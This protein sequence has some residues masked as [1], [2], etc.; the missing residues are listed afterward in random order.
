[1]AGTFD[2]NAALSNNART[3]ANVRRRPPRAAVFGRAIYRGP[4]WPPVPGVFAG[5]PMSPGASRKN[6][7]YTFELVAPGAGPGVF[8]RT[9]RHDGQFSDGAAFF[10][11]EG[12]LQTDDRPLAARHQR[13]AF[14]LDLDKP[15]HRQ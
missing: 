3:A 7:R 14:A 8:A 12:K 6:A 11:R 2:E 15:N 5:E 4:S 10:N 9:E 1:M 13:A